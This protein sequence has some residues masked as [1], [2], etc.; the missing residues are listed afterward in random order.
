MVIQI[1]L[2]YDHDTYGNLEVRVTFCSSLL[3][4]LVHKLRHEELHSLKIKIS[5]EVY[6][7]T[8]HA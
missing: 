4:M 7:I 3:I 5:Y 8:Q 2:H 6:K 1:Y